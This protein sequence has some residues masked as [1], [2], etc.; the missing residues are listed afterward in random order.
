MN[1]NDS[2]LKAVNLHKKYQLDQVEVPVLKGV[3]LEVCSGEFLAVVGVSGSGKS[4]LMHLLGALDTPDKGTVCFNGVDIF[5][6]PDTYR[7]D[8]RN[9]EFGFVFQFYHL[10]PELTVLEN[11]MMP[12]LVGATVRRWLGGAEE[13][14]AQARDL[15]CRVGLEHRIYHLPAQ[16][17]GGERQRVAIAR[18]IINKPVILFADEPTGNLDIRTGRQ[19]FDQLVELNQS[20][21]TIIMVTHDN[22]LA[23]QAHR[24]VRL[25]DGRVIQ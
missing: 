3:D 23:K 8:L 21:Q 13:I 12:L 22:D 16:L 6:A 2:I 7:D 25:H 14:E 4:T 15:L 1:K 20:G 19:I 11:A 18:A 5:T 10:L 9:R 24:I 17:S